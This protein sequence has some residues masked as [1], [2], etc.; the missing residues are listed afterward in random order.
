MYFI[1]KLSQIKNTDVFLYEIFDS[2]STY[3]IF[4]WFISIRFFLKT[5]WSYISTLISIWIYKVE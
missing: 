1:L 4:Y 3:I 5:D 2:I